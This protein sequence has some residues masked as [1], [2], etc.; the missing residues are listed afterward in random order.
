M[1][2]CVCVCGMYVV[3]VCGGGGGGINEHFSVKK[4]EKKVEMIVDANNAKVRGLFGV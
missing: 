3:C 2:V 1:C 4:R